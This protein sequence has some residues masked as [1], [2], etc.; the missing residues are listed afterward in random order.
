MRDTVGRCWKCVEND[1]NPPCQPRALFIK[2]LV[3]DV[4]KDDTEQMPQEDGADGAVGS[5]GSVPM[6]DP[7][8]IL[9]PWDG[10]IQKI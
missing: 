2:G 5:V 6:P 3:Q 8:H 1:M 7:W 9:A 10:F 4:I